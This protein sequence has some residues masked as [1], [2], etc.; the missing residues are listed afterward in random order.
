M[1]EYSSL[2]RDP[3]GGSAVWGA[4]LGPSIHMFAACLWEVHIIV[5]D[6]TGELWSYWSDPFWRQYWFSMCFLEDGH[7]ES[8]IKYFAI[9]RTVG[10]ESSFLFRHLL[11][12]GD[13]AGKKRN[14]QLCL[15]RLNRA[16]EKKKEK[17]KQMH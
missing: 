12:T 15:K 1:E 6:V 8:V 2:E 17:V 11:D 14:C 13:L 16:T 4:H 9:A 7:C 10:V 5:G 3:G